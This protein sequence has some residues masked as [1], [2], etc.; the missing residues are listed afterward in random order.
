MRIVY[1]HGFASS[2]NS[3][4]ARFFLERFRQAGVEMEVPA[5]DRGDFTHL[6]ITSQLA[7]ICR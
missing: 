5:L 3:A 1:L 2:P 6:S 4:K 7:A